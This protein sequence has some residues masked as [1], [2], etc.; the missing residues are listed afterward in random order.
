MK[1]RK[2]GSFL[3]AIELAKMAITAAEEKQASDILLLD[4]RG[5]CSFA[6]YFVILTGESER[7]LDAITEE[8]RQK[9][10]AEGERPLHIEGTSGSGWVLM[11]Y[12][13]VVV[14]IFSSED[15]DNY[16]LDDLWSN[17]SPVLRIQ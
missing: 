16:A 3:E 5:V 15:R 8:I 4:T 7:Q 14:H 9:L 2:E 13:D 6:D 10:K 1:P 17:A 11:D 12:G